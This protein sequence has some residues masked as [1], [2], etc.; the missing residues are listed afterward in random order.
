MFSAGFKVRV[1]SYDFAQEF[2]ANSETVISGLMGF[3]KRE[4]EQ[5]LEK[6]RQQ[7]FK[8]VRAL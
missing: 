6:F 5:E 1:P 7:Q 4:Q 2:L 8:L 3:F